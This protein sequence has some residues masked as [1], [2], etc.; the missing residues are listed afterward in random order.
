MHQTSVPSRSYSKPILPQAQ[1]SGITPGSHPQASHTP[2]WS[3][4]CISITSTKSTQLP[5]AFNTYQKLESAL[6]QHCM[7]IHSSEGSSARKRLVV[8]VNCQSHRT[9][10]SQDRADLHNEAVYRSE[11]VH[12]H[13]HS[14]QRQSRAT[15]SRDPATASQGRQRYWA[16]P[17]LES[18]LRSSRPRTS[19]HFRDAA[20]TNDT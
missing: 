5:P 11:P 1:V 19:S 10:R 13:T 17:P 18:A 12:A 20:S 15:P 6:N 14:G 2:P 8:N 4:H 7:V 16:A 3:R 9:L